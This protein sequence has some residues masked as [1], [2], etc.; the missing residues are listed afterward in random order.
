MFSLDDIQ[1]GKVEIAPDIVKTIIAKTIDKI[2]GTRLISKIL[3]DKR[4]GFLPGKKRQ[5]MISIDEDERIS[6]NLHLAVNFGQNIPI[7]SRKIKE[8]VKDEIESTTPYQVSDIKIYIDKIDE[9]LK[10]D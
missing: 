5:G 9:L 2:D 8:K 1:S 3:A 7:I 6:V 10:K 4:V